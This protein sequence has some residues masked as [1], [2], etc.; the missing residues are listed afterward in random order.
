MAAILNQITGHSF[1]TI[2]NA[3][4]EQERQATVDGWRT[5][6]YHW[7]KEAHNKSMQATPNGAPDG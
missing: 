7:K 3:G 4:S 1:S 2:Y 5:Y 6:L